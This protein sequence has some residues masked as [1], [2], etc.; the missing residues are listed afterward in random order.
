MHYKAI[1]AG[2]LSIF[3]LSACSDPISNRTA[4]RAAKG[5]AIGAIATAITDGNILKGAVVGGAIG[6]I[7]SKNQLAWD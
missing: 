2:V 4:D 6:A 5:A 7:T 3:V 1:L